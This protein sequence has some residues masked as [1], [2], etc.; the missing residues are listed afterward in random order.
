MLF[1]FSITSRAM[2]QEVRLEPGSFKFRANSF[3]KSFPLYGRGRSLASDWLAPDNGDKWQIERL[4]HTSPTSESCCAYAV[5]WIV[6]D[7]PTFLV[8]QRRGSLIQFMYN[9]V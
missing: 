8:G 3:A 7:T 2:C 6:R 1:G 4:D 5:I 9:L